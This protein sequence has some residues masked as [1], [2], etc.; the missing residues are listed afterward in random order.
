MRSLGQTWTCL[1]SVSGLQNPLG[2]SAFDESQ[3]C[4]I[5]PGI[6]ADLLSSSRMLN[7]DQRA[8]PFWWVS[9]GDPGGVDS[10]LHELLHVGGGRLTWEEPPS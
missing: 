4:F 9:T 8:E 5:N 6:K 1:Q 2:P 3:T 7:T 10:D